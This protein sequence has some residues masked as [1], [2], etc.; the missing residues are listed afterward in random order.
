MDPDWPS[1]RT[2][3]PRSFG[4]CHAIARSDGAP[5][6]RSGCRRLSREDQYLDE[7]LWHIRE[8]NRRWEAGD[9]DVA[10]LE[11][12]ILERYFAPVHRHEVVCGS[13]ARAAGRPS[14]RPT[15]GNA[16]KPRPDFISEAEPYP[17]VTVWGVR[18]WQFWGLV[19]ALVATVFLIGYGSSIMR[20]LRPVAHPRRAGRCGLPSR[21]GHRHRREAAGGRHD[22]RHR[23]DRRQRRPF[24]PQGECDQHRQ[25]RE[26]RGHHRRQRRLHHEGAG[27]HLP[28]RSRGASR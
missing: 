18:T 19:F 16:R 14:R 5:I 2:T 10:F 7:G 9:Y 24:G 27:R 13:R 21:T 8:R 23:L 20:R 6:R 17:I 28:A 22:R 26:V 4:S 12:E 15:R 11:N 1:S 3:A 25:R